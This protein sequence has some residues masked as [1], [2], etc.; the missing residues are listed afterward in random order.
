MKIVIFCGGV[1]SRMW[2]M[3]RKEKPKQFQKLVGDRTMFQQ[4]VQRIKKGFSAKDIFVSTGKE[5]AKLVRE[6]AP[7]IPPQN[8]IIEPMMRDNTAAVG[9]A[10]VY[11]NKKYPGTLM[12]AIWGADHLVRNEE[13]FVK[14]LNAARKVCEEKHCIVKVDVNPTFPST[15]LGYVQIGKPKGQ[16]DE[17]QIFE[18]KRHCEKPDLKTAKR[19]LESWGYLW[20]TGYFVWPVDFALGL[21]RKYSPKTYKILKTIEK[22]IGQRDFKKVLEREYAKIEKKSIDYIIFEKLDPKEQLVIP[23]DL[24]WADVG[25]WNILKDQFSQNGENVTSGLHV[26]IDTKNSL[27]YGQPQKLIATIGIEDMIIVDTEDALL[28]CPKD[29]AAEVRQMVKEI[30]AKGITKYL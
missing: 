30:E 27:V 14:A 25:T 8:I 13:V 28:I 20:N 24:G 10:L 12:A 11:L 4:T 5:Y 16:I 7:E 17:F 19:F 9:Y 3:S 23:A 26:G 6:Q 18:F 22:S 15:Q 1:G 21:Y 29:K 2:P